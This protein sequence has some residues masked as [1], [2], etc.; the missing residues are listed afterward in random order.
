MSAPKHTPGPWFYVQEG[1]SGE[2]F[3]CGVSGTKD[4]PEFIWFDDSIEAERDIANAH[5]IAAAPDMLEALKQLKENAPD[6]WVPA[7]VVHAI[8]DAAIAKAEGR[9]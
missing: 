8:C 6:Q 9:A 2:F 3:G 1:S 7:S 5:L 4:G